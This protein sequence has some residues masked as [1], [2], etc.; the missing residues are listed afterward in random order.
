MSDR[1]IDR[2]T[3]P[4]RRAPFQGVVNRTLEAPGPTG[5]SVAPI[6]PPEGAP[7]VLAR[8]H[9]R[10]WLRQPERLRRPD[11]HADARRGWRTEG[12]ATT[13]STSTALCSPDARR[14]ADRPQPSTPSASAS[15][16]EFAGP[17][18]GYSAMLPKDCA[19]VPEDPA[20]ERLLDRGVRQVAPDTRRTAGPAGPFDRW[21][22]AL[23]LRLL[24]G[25]PRRRVRPVR[26]RA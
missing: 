8:P 18:P 20:G 21:P 9:R 26:P 17:F 14:A 16:G 11:Q 12:C 7:N 23:G 6:T 10:C 5:T 15:I 4:I 19:A 1:T 13:A 2:S 3:L 22:N 25:V 24:L